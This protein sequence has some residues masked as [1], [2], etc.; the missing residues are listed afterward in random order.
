MLRLSREVGQKVTGADGHRIGSVRDLVVTGLDHPVV[1]AILVGG[2]EHRLVPWSDVADFSRDS[3]VLRP[4][5]GTPVLDQHVDAVLDPEQ[6][7]LIRDV[8]DTQVIDTAGKRMARVGDVLLSR[9]TDGRLAVLGVDVG[10]GAVSHR[11][12]ARR[13]SRRLPEQVVVWDDIHLTSDRGHRVQ[14]A[15]PAAVIHRLDT[16]ALAHLLDALPVARAADV[17]EVIDPERSAE[18]LCLLDEDMGVRVM[19]EVR[20]SVRPGILDAMPEASAHRVRR[21]LRDHNLLSRRRFSRHG[22]WRR[23]WSGT[24]T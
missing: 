13:L 23:G 16:P 1:T 10:M 18:A 15:S 2:P 21:G 12:G 24:V 9:Q 6:L 5:V 11:L 22:P 8:L 19:S 14:L 20:E 7:L 17:V 3:V 4:G